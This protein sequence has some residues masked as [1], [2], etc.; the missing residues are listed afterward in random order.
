MS[1]HFSLRKS[2]I[3]PK[4][5]IKRPSKFAKRFFQAKNFQIVKG[6]PCDEM[7]FFVK[8]GRTVMYVFSTGVEK[9]LISSTGPKNNP[10][11]HS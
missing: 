10:I 3:V 6:V 9:T 4:K 2:L 11:C 7:K 5:P 8:K 1:K